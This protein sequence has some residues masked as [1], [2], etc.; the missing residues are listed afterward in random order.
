M[1]GGGGHVWRGGVCVAGGHAWQGR[2]MW[3]E[4]V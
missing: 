3:Q 4:G 1:C 2:C